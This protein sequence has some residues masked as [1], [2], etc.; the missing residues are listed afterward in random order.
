MIRP[1]DGIVRECFYCRWWH[2]EDGTCRVEFPYTV[3]DADDCCSAF[4]ADG[5]RGLDRQAVSIIERWLEWAR[6]HGHLDHASGIVKD[7]RE[8]I[9]NAPR[10]DRGER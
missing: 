5:E 4:D 9:A 1:L 2:N 6:F 8:L 3:H 10:Q 7:S